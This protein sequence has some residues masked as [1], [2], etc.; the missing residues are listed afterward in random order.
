MFGTCP[1]GVPDILAPS[2]C[3]I[4]SS[5]KI[6]GF[7]AFNI[8]FLLAPAMKND[9][10]ICNPQ[11]RNVLKARSPTNS[12]S[13]D[14]TRNVLIGQTLSS[15][16]GNFFRIFPN[17]IAKGFIGPWQCRKKKNFRELSLKS[18]LIIL[19]TDE[20]RNIRFHLVFLVTDYR[21]TAWNIA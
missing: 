4:W 17:A 2:M 13:R 20:G 15:E 12:V 18:I 16:Y 10:S 11:L 14:V 5:K 21:V 3:D 9:S 19:M 8:S 1:E 7:I 6:C